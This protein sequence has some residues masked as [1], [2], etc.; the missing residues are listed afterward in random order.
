MNDPETQAAQG[1][2]AVVEAIRKQAGDLGAA[3]ATWHA[4]NDTRPCPA[5]RHAANDAMD[6]ID[7]TLAGMHALRRSLVSEIRASDNAGA[8]RA[9]ELLARSRPGAS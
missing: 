6:A 2:A 1:G 7:G 9:D 4:R 5:A 3:L 8:I